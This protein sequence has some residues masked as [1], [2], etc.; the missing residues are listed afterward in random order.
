MRG[1]LHASLLGDARGLRCCGG[2]C[3]GASALDA[4]TSGCNS[5]PGA[6]ERLADRL[7]NQQLQIV[8][9]LHCTRTRGSRIDG[10]VPIIR[11]YFLGLA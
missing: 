5:V 11:G 1:A 2:T 9:L 7:H 10:E 6:P 4:G 8:Q 3:V